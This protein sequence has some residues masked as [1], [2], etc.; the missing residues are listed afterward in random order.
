[1]SATKLACCLCAGRSKVDDRVLDQ[2]RNK[3]VYVGPSRLF[4][5]GFD[6]V[7]CIIC[8]ENLA[9]SFFCL[10]LFPV[11]IVHR[12]MELFAYRLTLLTERNICHCY[13]LKVRKPSVNDWQSGGLKMPMLSFLYIYFQRKYEHPGIY[14]LEFW[15]RENN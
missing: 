8:H 14:L 7:C 1:M 4:S 11:L 5:I 15:S 13:R 12:Y 6:I 2:R 3:L 10:T 9:L